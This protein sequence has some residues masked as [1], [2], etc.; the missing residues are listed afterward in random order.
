MYII[1]QG[2]RRTHVERMKLD[3]SKYPLLALVDEPAQLR[4]LPQPQL[5]KLSD[6]L[7]DYLLNSVS[8]SSGHLAS[9]LGWYQYLRLSMI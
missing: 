4:Q 6:E 5:G 7:R 2:L 3:S 8:Q 1:E 9:G